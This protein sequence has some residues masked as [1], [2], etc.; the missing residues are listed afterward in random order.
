M[1]APILN[2]LVVIA[3]GLTFH[4]LVGQQV[5]QLGEVTTGQKLLLG[6]GTTAGVAAMT[7]V[8]WPFLRRIGF[9]FHF[10][11]NWRDQAIRKMATLSAFTVGYVVTNQLGYLLVPI[12]AYGIQGGYTAYSTAFIFFQ[13]PHGVFAVSVMT[14][15]LPPLSEQAV[16]GDWDAFR[17]TLARGIR[18]TAAVL[19]PAALGYLALA[20]PI[21]RLLLEHGVVTGASTELLTRV[22]VVFVLGLVPFSTFQLL[23]RAFYALQDT[24]TTFLLNLVAVG[25]NVVANLLLFSL[26][27]AP[28]KV[29]GLALGHAAHYTVGSGLLLA[30]LS[31]RIGGLEGGRIL[32]AVARMLAAAVV[33]AVVAALVGRAAGAPFGPGLLRDLVTVVAGVGAGLCSY[34]LAARLLRVEEIGVL[35][36]VVR[37]RAR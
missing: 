6:L 5:P 21:V 31:R 33:M 14:A 35:L 11:W 24:R 28:W 2:N 10:V 22:L 34:L 4:L 13:L 27:P 26:L 23:L 19:L 7:L 16:A 1:F 29:P 30:S 37:R 17:A 36:D 12:L 9:R 8:Q 20:G 32:R 3:V 18:L 15:L 25:T